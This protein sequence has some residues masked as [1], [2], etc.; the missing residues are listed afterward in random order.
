[1]IKNG[2]TNKRGKMV[3]LANG[4][5]GKTVKHVGRKQFGKYQS[6]YGSINLA[7]C[8]INALSIYHPISLLDNEDD[9]LVSDIEE[10]TYPCI[11][12]LIYQ[13]SKLSTYQSI[14]IALYQSI[15]LSTYRPIN[16]PTYQSINVWIYEST[17]K[18][19]IYQCITLTRCPSI[20]LSI[21]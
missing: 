19:S 20:N 11:Y 5:I 14:N 2:K 3:K 16:L 4:K 13:D 21:S 17:T 15:D 9:R 18:L 12:L 8:H 6:N 7:V 10:S 1:M